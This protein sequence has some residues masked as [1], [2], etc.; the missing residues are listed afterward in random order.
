MT[1]TDMPLVATRSG[2]EFAELSR[3]IKQR[4]LL[5]RRHGSYA[6]MFALNAA[7]MAIGWTAF[8]LLG[9]SWWQLL[10]AAFFAVTFTQLAFI[11]HDAGHRQIFRRR[12]ANDMIGYLHGALVGIS[13]D[14]WVDK[15][16]LHHTSPNH[17]DDDPDL[18]IPVLAFTDEQAASRRGFLRWMIKYQALLFF[19]ILL[20]EGLN[21]HVSSVKA[22]FRPGIRVSRLAATLL[23]VHIIG[24][25]TAVFLI[26]S[27]AQAIAFIAVHHGLW[28]LY[29]GCSFAPNHKG[30]PTLTTGLKLD[31]LRK[32]IL[33]SR[34]VRGGWLTDYAFGGLNYQIE[35]H[36]FPT[37]P[38][39]NL[40]H[41]QPLVQQ[42]CVRHDLP[43]HQA[44]VFD[45]YAQVLRHLHAIGAP[46]RR[47][48]LVS[49]S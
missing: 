6:L 10:T 12:R 11:G 44:T 5:Q 31:H 23:A 22:V 3:V 21:L 26:L 33:T 20:L 16:N 27:P 24:Y 4:G 49:C 38:R 14:W 2:G 46:L 30:M 7:L 42:F 19:P 39:A 17:E 13:Y 37:M 8:V 43:Y 18:R 15:H 35:H 48:K 34:N 28:G 47:P 29:M 9:H 1:F 40:R 25:L 32:Q 41:A 45:S 36:L